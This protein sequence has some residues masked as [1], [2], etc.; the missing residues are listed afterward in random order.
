MEIRVVII[1]TFDPLFGPIPAV[2]LIPA[3]RLG[4]LTYRARI[5]SITTIFYRDI[6]VILYQN[7]VVYLF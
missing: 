6:L 5:Y 3:I 7:A 2:R 4:V 1:T